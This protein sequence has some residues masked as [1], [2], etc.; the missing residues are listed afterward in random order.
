M[1]DTEAHTSSLGVPLGQA[2]TELDPEER[3]VEKHAGRSLSVDRRAPSL[4]VG[5]PAAAALVGAASLLLPIGWV[6]LWAPYELDMADL[7]R[8]IAV[9][10]HGA[11]HL[12]LE[13]ARNDVPILSDL[14]KGQA[15][16]SA[17]AL[18]FQAFG[19]SD[20]AGRLPLALAA[21]LGLA[22]TYVAVRRLVDA[23]AAAYATLVLATMP[24]Y[25]LQARTMLGDG[26]LLASAALS[27]SALALLTFDAS[28]TKRARAA[29]VA[30]ALLGLAGG[31]ATRGVLL[32]VA[33]PALGVGLGWGLWRLAGQRC[34]SRA[35]EL[36]G[37]ASALVGAAALGVGIWALAS[38]SPTLYLELLGARLEP[39]AKLPTHDAVLH[40]LGF[41]LFPWSTLAPFALALALR[42]DNA[43]ASDGGLRL[44]LGAVFLLALGVHGTAAQYIGE[45]PFVGTFALA[46]L[47][48]IALR[49]AE[50][51]AQRTRLMA[52]G[53]AALIVIFYNDLSAAPER[54]LEPFSVRDPAF[55]ESFTPAAK[56]WMKYGSL[57]CLLVALF[58]L[59]DIESRSAR[60]W[61]GPDSDYARWLTRLQTAWRG[62]LPA[63]L[64]A[65]TLLLGAIP[66]LLFLEGR[67]VAIPIAAAL[68]P[69]RTV[70]GYAF[71]VVPLVLALPLAFW[72]ARDVA[73]VAVAWLPL[74]RPR[75]A[76]IAFVAFGLS[77]SLGY[78][79]VLA[80]QLSPRNVFES[81][82]KRAQPGEPLGVIGQ[83][84]R[85]APYYAGT[86]VQPV[87][88][89][90]AGLDWLL[91][92]GGERRWLVLGARDLG[93]LEH[94]Y[95][96][97]HD[98]PR[99]LPVLDAVSSEVLLASNE[100]RPG[101]VNQ[102]PLAEWISETPPEPARPLDI[103]M[104][105]Q[106]RC[107]GWAVTD[108][109]GRPVDQVVTGRRYDFRIYWEVVAPIS[110]NWKTFIHI[111]S[112]RRRYN[113][114]HDTL[115]GKYPL[116]FWKPGDFITDVHAIQ[117]E[118]HF[119]G[120]TYQVYFGLYIGDKRLAVKRGR[121]QDNRIT[122]GPLVVR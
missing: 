33:C 96:E 79:P 18:G 70:A 14:G 65:L 101:E 52:L 82:R 73:G 100:L 108:K 103:D 74:P 19:L 114:D 27:A 98:P 56:A 111:D 58:A 46:A 5:M 57:G 67:G 110:G 117:L 4:G 87:A 49:D 7:S 60:G 77:L 99:N 38:A 26:L 35:G 34:P 15:P 44:C 48:G 118:P 36:S 75:L 24:L 30:A 116:H 55:P 107:L 109:D 69:Y 28:L 11:A 90:R 81:F 93:Q 1:N 2:A 59:G 29:L 13:G 122:A 12:A 61:F 121:H 6:G 22:A 43:S 97:H 105:G 64:G 25:F 3:S 40:A 102:N 9:G 41:G 89:A 50:R 31:F 85:V 45:V 47:I 80:S 94:L 112:G 20:W 91:E 119:A 76:L 86:D 32:G 54:A 104:N 88:S 71:M 68:G 63:L 16:F 78:Y 115:Q 95:R 37:A 17:V 51:R 39:P 92:A 72:L 42:T 23:L 66:V 120:S 83:I 8:R 84:S 106:L 62:R 21:A 10:L 53:A 113:G